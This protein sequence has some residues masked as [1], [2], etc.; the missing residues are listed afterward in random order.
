MS[1]KIEDSEISLISSQSF[2]PIHGTDENGNSLQNNDNVNDQNGRVVEEDNSQKD[3]EINPKTGKK[4]KDENYRLGGRPPLLTLIVLALGPLIS[5]FVSSMYGIVNTYWVS[6]ALGEKGMAAVSLFANLDSLGRAFG[7]FMNCSA[8]QKI[9]SLFGQKKGHEA[10]QVICDL[11]RCCFVSGM[12]VP[13]LIIPIAKPLGKWFGSDDEILQMGFDYLVILSSCS[14]VSCIFLMFCGCLQAEGRT[15]LVC[16]AQISTFVLNMCVFCPLFLFVFKIGIRGASLATICSEALPGIVFFCMYFFQKDDKE[17]NDSTEFNDLKE[18]MIDGKETKENEKKN[19]C[20]NFKPAVKP[21]L[22]GLFKKFSPHTK[23]AL[24]VGVSQLVSNCSR[25]IPSILQRK[26]MGEITKHSDTTSFTDAMSGFNTVFRLAQFTD[27]FRLAM[28]M[29]LLPTS[30]YAFSSGRYHRFLRLNIHGCWLNLAWGFFTFALIQI[31][32]KQIASIF[33][34]SPSFI[35][36]SSKMM[37]NANIEAPIAWV[38]FNIQTLLQ[39]LSFGG[40]ATCYSFLSHF[41]VNIGTYC[42]LYYTDKTNVP[43][44]MYAYALSAGIS[45][46]FGIFF[47][48]KPIKFV[49]DKM[50]EA[51]GDKSDIVDNIDN[52]TSETKSINVLN[53][54]DQNDTEEKSFV[55]PEEDKKNDL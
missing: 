14:T 2:G 21:K 37:K 36:A 15:F 23:P 11:F 28:S 44:M 29:S 17:K 33:S 46:F 39:A 4:K 10:G 31:F 19:C 25:S 3:D 53:E 54:T 24:S 27:S 13:A 48:I 12:I 30:S 42:L 41:I 40:R 50:K 8:S 45:I 9:S 18:P 6:K 47:V 7:Y 5:Q 52:N 1:K 16:I 35:E 55:E 49:Y 26:F 22:S 43:R 51:S 32:C 38:R 34:K 20:S